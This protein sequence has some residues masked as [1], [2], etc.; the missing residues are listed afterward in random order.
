MAAMAGREGGQQGVGRRH[1]QGH[2]AS[3]SVL[4]VFWL[5]GLV[6]PHSVLRVW[7]D[8]DGR[9]FCVGYP[10]VCE[11]LLPVLLDALDKGLVGSDGEDH[12]EAAEDL[13]RRH[14]HVQVDADHRTDES[15]RL[16]HDTHLVVD[17]RPVPLRVPLMHIEQVG[18]QRQPEYGHLAQR[19]RQ[20]RRPED[21][22]I[23]GDVDG[24]AA[25]ASP[26]REGR[27]DERHDST[28]DPY[29]A[30]H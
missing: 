19:H 8:G 16:Q 17:Q 27:T 21:D 11:G 2:L 3:L 6:S 14:H 5:V 26:R 25:D 30:I 4:C 29:D 15:C 20:M 28:A 10:C 9:Q 13:D 12:H 23:S 7:V 24:P 18:G 22:H 1:N